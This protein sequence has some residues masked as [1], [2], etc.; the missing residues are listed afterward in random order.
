LVWGGLPSDRHNGTCASPLTF[1]QV[2]AIEEP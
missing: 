2:E 1:D